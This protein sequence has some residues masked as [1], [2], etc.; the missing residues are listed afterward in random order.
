MPTLP[1]LDTIKARLYDLVPHR[2]IKSEKAV[3][4][5]AKAVSEIERTEKRVEQQR[6]AAV[7]SVGRARSV[8]DATETTL[9]KQIEGLNKQIAKANKQMR[10]AQA[11]SFAKQDELVSIGGK[12]S[13][14]KANLKALAGEEDL[15]AASAYP[16]CFSACTTDEH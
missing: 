5:V 3:G 4:F 7:R 1:A 8:K 9:L 10:D 15:H 6:R 14:V 16:L 13:R 2:P 12:L 11:A